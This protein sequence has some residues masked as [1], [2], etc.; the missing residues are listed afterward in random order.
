MLYKL[1]AER[2]EMHCGE[3]IMYTS[4]PHQLV[5]DRLITMQ[6]FTGK[7][8][9]LQ[10]IF[11]LETRHSSLWQWHSPIT[12]ASGHS[13]CAGVRVFMCVICKM[14]VVI[15]TWSFTHSWIVGCKLKTWHHFLRLFDN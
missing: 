9:V 4:W 11:Y 2:F 12:T 10:Y 1:Q 8:L 15:M 3:R 13:C 14:E 6:C 7:P 5:I